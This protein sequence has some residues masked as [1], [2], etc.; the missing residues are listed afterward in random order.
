MSIYKNHETEVL[1]EF[2][3]NDDPDKKTIMLES[4]ILFYLDMLIKNKPDGYMKHIIIQKYERNKD[5]NRFINDYDFL[6]R[7]NVAK[8]GRHQDLDIL[9]NDYENE[10]VKEVLLNGRFKDIDKYIDNDIYLKEIINVKI[11]RY[12]D[13]IIKNKKI[14]GF[15]TN[16][17]IDIGRKKDLDYFIKNEKLCKSQKMAIIRHGHEEHLKILKENDECTQEQLQV[18]K[19]KTDEILNKAITSEYNNC[20]AA[21]AIV[22]RDCDLDKLVYDKSEFVQSMVL[23][24]KR[25]QDIK[26]LINNSNTKKEILLKIAEFDLDD[27]CFEMLLKRNYNAVIRK[28]FNRDSQRVLDFYKKENNS[29]LSNEIIQSIIVN[30]TDQNIVYELRKKD[31]SET[32]LLLLKTIRSC[33]DAMI[34]IVDEDEDVRKLAFEILQDPENAI[35]YR[36]MIKKIL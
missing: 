20:R 9:I 19:L 24:H 28:L 21:V 13:F 5:L 15:L 8:I 35:E 2:I 3:K 6:I 18:I 25:P 29:C 16:Y 14:N 23:S 32:K 4:G 7:S 17:I 34:L 10:V 1:D 36:E 12:L 30:L 33:A 31:D 27:E 22:G 11:D 26:T